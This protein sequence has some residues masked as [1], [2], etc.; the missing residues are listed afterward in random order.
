[1]LPI[2]LRHTRGYKLFF[3][4]LFHIINALMLGLNLMD[5]EYFRFTSKRSTFDILYMFGGGGNDLG[6]LWG[7]FLKDFWFVILIYITLIILSDFFYRKTDKSTLQTSDRSRFFKKNSIWFLILIPSMFAI[8]RGGFGLKPIGIIQANRYTNP[9]NISFILPTPFTMIK[10]IDQGG[11]EPVVY[12]PEQKALHYFNPIKKTEPQGILANKTNVVI[13]MLES[14]GSEF[15]GAY[16]NGKGYTPFMDSIID[17]SLTFNYSFANGKRSIEA[18]PAVI[19][20]M[21]TLM[22]NAYIS[23]PYGNNKINSLP[24][25]LKKHGYESAFFH[26][27]TNGS[28][29]FDGFSEIC[30]FDHYFGRFEYDNDAHFDKTWGILDHYFNPWSARKM[31]KLKEPFF[32]TL[33]TISSHHPYFIPKQFRSQVKRGPQKICASINYGDIA[34][35]NFFVEAKK[36][37]WYGNTLFVLLADHT[38][39]TKSKVYNQRTHIFRIPIAFYHPGGN[40]K[41]EKSNRAFQQL[42]IMPTI[43]DLL[44][45]ETDYYAFGNSFYNS[46]EGEALTYLSGSFNYFKN[47]HLIV[48]SNGK[49]QNLYNYTKNKVELDDSLNYFSR[50]VESAERKI[51]ATIQRYNTDLIKNRTTAK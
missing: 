30:G 20:S 26:A 21:P 10:T 37:S 47:G 28:M 49:A 45:I 3:R 27:A 46:D 38:P 1:M 39:A 44:N 7:T 25:I 6:Q 31:S 16:N 33:F 24:N 23:S 8:G 41:A 43:L 42:D 36:Q 14:F 11:L 50:E 2:P 22:E 17:Q 15:V 19:A 5:V 51:K 34:L 48:Y 13:I 40:L 32:S 9:E 12:M 18:I 29:S 4:L 35:R